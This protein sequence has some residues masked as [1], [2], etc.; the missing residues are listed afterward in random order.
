MNSYDFAIRDIHRIQRRFASQ[1]QCRRRQRVFELSPLSPS[2]YPPMRLGSGLAALFASL[3]RLSSTKLERTEVAC[4]GSHGTEPKCDAHGL[5]ERLDV[6]DVRDGRAGCRRCA[7]WAT[8][9]LTARTGTDLSFSGSCARTFVRFTIR[10][11][12]PAKVGSGA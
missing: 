7:I 10:I 6:R 5:L 8:P 2:R 11:P 3:P 4:H 9:G 12:R 1:A